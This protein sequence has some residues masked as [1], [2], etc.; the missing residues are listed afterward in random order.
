MSKTQLRRMNLL[1]S[2]ISSD[3]IEHRS[4]LAARY[5]NKNPGLESLL[6]ALAL[7]RH[8]ASSGLFLKA[9]ASKNSVESLRRHNDQA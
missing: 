9:N 7:H 1:R 8:K 4:L 3:P 5:L 2:I 6:R